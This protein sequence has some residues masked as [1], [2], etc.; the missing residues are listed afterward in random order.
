METHTLHLFNSLARREEEFSPKVP[1]K[2]GVYVCGATVQ[3]K[4]HI[5]H[6]RSAVAFDILRRWLEKSGYDVTFIRNVTDI[7]DKILRKAEEGGEEWWALAYRFERA[8]SRDYSLLNVAP[9]TYEPRATGQIPEM[10]ELVEILLGKG[11][12]YRVP[13][14]EAEGCDVYFDTEKWEDYGALTRQGEGALEGPEEEG[15]GKGTQGTSPSGRPPNPRS[16]HP[17]RGTPPSGRGA[18][19]GTWS[20]RP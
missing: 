16:P 6:M 9:P 3:G 10:E 20:A 1:G 13:R 7:D 14:P 12:A 8:F 15:R 4:A 11:Y 19:A 5:G 18:P 17:P 2:A